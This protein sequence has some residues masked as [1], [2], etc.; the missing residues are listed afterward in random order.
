VVLSCLLILNH[1]CYYYCQA[2]SAEGILSAVQYS[3]LTAKDAVLLSGTL[4]ALT[5]ASSKMAEAIANKVACNK[6]LE[7]CT[8]DE[9]GYYGLYSPVTIVSET[10]KE[11][12]KN[13]GAS[14]V[15]SNTGCMCVGEG[16]C[17]GVTVCVRE[18]VCMCNIYI[19][20]CTIQYIYIYA[21]I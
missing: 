10:T 4:G 17:V 15:N 2:P 19:C 16:V 5:L 20:I 3:G 9:E 6:E 18:S 7:D 21:Y 1:I 13:R 12:G 14:A 8:D 11:F